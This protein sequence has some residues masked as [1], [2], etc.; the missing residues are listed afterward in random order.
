M[1]NFIVMHKF[2]YVTNFQQN[3]LGYLSEKLDD[4]TL[5]SKKVPLNLKSYSNYTFVI[6]LQCNVLN[7]QIVP[8]ILF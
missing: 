3:S 5:R 2:N 1:T 6:K 4:W 8:G 7:K